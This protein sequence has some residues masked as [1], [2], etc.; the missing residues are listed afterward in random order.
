MAETDPGD[1]TVAE[2]RDAIA[3]V[4]DS[5]TLESMLE[6]ERDG[7]D[8]KTAKD[9]IQSRLDEVG[10]ESP[11]P[12]SLD[13]VEATTEEIRETIREELDS[14]NDSIVDALTQFLKTPQRANVYVQTVGDGARKQDLPDS[15]GLNADRVEEI[16]DE[17]R[18]EGLVEH[19]GGGNYRATKPR[20]ALRNLR[21]R[22]N[23]LIESET[24][25]RVGGR[26]EFSPD[27]L[28]YRV[29]F[30]SKDDEDV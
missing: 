11:V 27:W 13:D 29:V 17:L 1:L 4:D 6:S 24:E 26:K 19:T 12:E 9:A 10:D 2:L 15:T 23:E 7:K 20:D 8:R 3:D 16:L 14:V 28:P 25:E 5:A 18:D 21:D 22:L 30:E